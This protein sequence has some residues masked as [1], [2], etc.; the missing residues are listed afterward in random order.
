MVY[1]P[2]TGLTIAGKDF[3]IGKAALGC[4]SIY[5]GYGFG[6]RTIGGERILEFA[7]ANNL[8]VGN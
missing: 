5:R 2:Q 6:K 8:A 4:E 3:N 1:A 7:V